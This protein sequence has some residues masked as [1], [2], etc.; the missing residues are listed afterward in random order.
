MNRIVR[1]T[2][3]IA[4]L[5]CALAGSGW[6]R[7]QTPAPQR[8]AAPAVEPPSPHMKASRENN[9]GVALMNRQQFEA[10]LGKFQR[11]CILDPQ[12]DSLPEHGH[13]LR[14]LQRL[15]RRPAK[16]LHEI[17]RA[18]PA[19]SARLVQP[20]PH[21]E[22]G[23]ECR[24]RHRGFSKSRRARSQGRRHAIFSRPSLFPAAAIRQSHRGFQE[25]RSSSIRSI[26]PPN[27]GWRKPMQRSGDKT[28][29]PGS[30]SNTSNT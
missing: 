9:I 28:A 23:R 15:R 7:K 8:A 14:E 3:P 4:V 10:A 21:G 6:Q 30:T 24:R 20:R 27:L 11:A 5:S 1:M 19:E 26:S 22:V 18:R 17:H 2:V 16:V 29:A 12:S 13:R 25:R